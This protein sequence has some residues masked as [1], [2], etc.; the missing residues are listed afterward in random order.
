MKNL[1][2][3]TISILTVLAV[4]LC[5]VSAFAD[6]SAETG[7]A[8]IP[9]FEVGR[10]ISGT[11]QPDSAAEIRVRAARSSQV[12]FTLT[13]TDDCGIKVAV[14]GSGISLEC[15]NAGLP[16]YTFTRYFGQNASHIISLTSGCT[17]GY[18]II[19]EPILEEPAPE[20]EPEAAPEA[21]PEA[22]TET[23]I[24]EAPAPADEPASEPMQKSDEA[25]V[26]EPEGKSV[27]EQQGTEENNIQEQQEPLAE[28]ETPEEPAVTTEE[29]EP[30]AETRETEQPIQ[31]ETAPET[32]ETEDQTAE[33]EQP[34]RQEEQTEEQQAEEQNPDQPE[35]A[36]TE[37]AAGSVE[38]II[39]KSLSP[40]ESWS[41][42]VRKTR[43]TILK[44]DVAEA[45]MIHMFV[46]GK[47]VLYS[48]QK[49]DR[50]TDDAGY[51]L[52]DTETNRGITSWDADPGSY[53]ISI[54]AG[55]NSIGARVAV[56]FKNDVEFAL[57]EEEQTTLEEANTSVE[58]VS[59]EIGSEPEGEV[60]GETENEPESA[61]PAERH[62]KLQLTWD[63]DEPAVGD[64]AHLRAVMTGYEDIKY[65][66]QWQNSTDGEYWRDIAGETSE[67]L[68]IMITDEMNNLTWRVMVYVETAPEAE[69]E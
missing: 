63:T 54:R 31:P 18:S 12:K 68:D 62:V 69:Q 60:E 51:T 11:I 24:E 4:L 47:D 13:L 58:E 46:E 38:I 35:T 1:L 17:V 29:N 23:S 20:A 59:E 6:E 3:K 55:E 21:V 22:E 39:A 7:E 26:D 48:I 56:R 16:V 15:P 53:L 33:E 28:D 42:T 67:N 45:E 34:V 8:S 5:A 41:G 19:S 27:E 64:V 37:N 14:D 43:P 10:G 66:L 65:S 9:T 30:A 2:K 61:L 57:W 40:D 44:L 49:S 36:N 25:P 32:V 52:T 50:I